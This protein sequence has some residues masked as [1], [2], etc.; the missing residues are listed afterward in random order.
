V[1][2]FVFLIARPH[3]AVWVCSMMSETKRFPPLLS[4]IERRRLSPLGHFRDG[5][6]SDSILWGRASPFHPFGRGSFYLA[7]HALHP[8]CHDQPGGPLP[9]GPIGAIVYPDT[10]W[11]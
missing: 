5:V 11:S 4:W 1:S 9:V 6:P 10:G 7:E 2:P 8:R 3:I